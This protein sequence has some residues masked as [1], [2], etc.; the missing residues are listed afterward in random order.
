MNDKKLIVLEINELNFDLVKQYLVKH[1]LPGFKDL[2]NS[3]DVVETYAESSYVELEPWIQWVSVHTGK[4]YA[5]HNIFRL[6]DGANLDIPLVFEKIEKK[7]LKVGAISP[8]N[9]RNNLL[10]PAYFIPDPWTK[11]QSDGSVFSEKLS[12]MLVQTVNDNSQEKLSIKSIL[13]LIEST[14]RSF[15]P[16]GTTELINLI[17]SSKGKHWKKALVL[18]Q[19]I[20]LV[21]LYL[22]KKYRPD[23]SFV[24][25]NAGAHIQ[26][27][28]FFNSPHIEKKNE[29]TQENPSWYVSPTEDPILDMLISYDKILQKYIKMSKNN[30]KVII[31]TGLTQ[32]PYDKVKYYY[33]LKNHVEFL[34][35]IGIVPTKVFPRMTRDFEITFEN[36]EVASNAMEILST[37]KMKRDNQLLFEEIENRGISL[38]ITLTYPNE[39]RET[40]T[41]VYDKGSEESIYSDVIFVAIK[42][43]MHIG[44]GFVFC[45]PGSVKNLPQKPVHIASLEKVILNAC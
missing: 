28:Y 34:K 2:F 15:N 31:A 38:F 1:S 37:V 4:T 8:M 12:K 30:Y 25:F 14:I 43:G 5:E 19:L 7:G 10:N 23:V 20:H 16:T 22:H 9:A 44:K 21:H 39:I 13:T 29:N 40:D 36:K 11:T 45:S 42:N 32:Q 26:H 18:D 33:R 17:L 27:H 24:F 41:L 3:F 35:K 6:G